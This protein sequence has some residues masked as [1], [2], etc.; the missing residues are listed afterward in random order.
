[1]A[2]VSTITLN[3]S[4]LCSLFG[5]ASMWWTLGHCFLIYFMTLWQLHSTYSIKWQNDFKWWIM[6]EALMGPYEDW[7]LKIYDNGNISGLVV[8]SQACQLSHLY[9]AR[10]RLWYLFVLFVP[11]PPVLAISPSPFIS[12]FSPLLPWHVVTESQDSGHHSGLCQAWKKPSL[13][14]G[15]ETQRLCWSGK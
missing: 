3:V 12:L 1:M 13:I 5:A 8:M 4:P 9:P 7:T 11:F 6:K 14:R 2:R 15:A 10:C